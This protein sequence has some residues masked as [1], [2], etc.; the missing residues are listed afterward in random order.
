M[1]N[2][3]NH[4][5]PLPFQMV[6]FWPV[7]IMFLLLRKLS[8]DL[9]LKINVRENRRVLKNQ[10]SKK[11]QETLDTRHRKQWIQDTGNSGY[12]TQETVDTRHRKQWI[13]DTGNSGYKTQETVKTRHPLFHV[14]CIH[15]FLCLVSTVSCVLYPLFPVS[16][17]HCFLC[18]VVFFFFAFLRQHW[19]HILNSFT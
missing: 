12:K 16:C 10:H 2:N 19:V 5:H 11:T 18:F 14:S 17:F 3:W 13:Q 15:C 8:S 1:K 7:L 9:I 4:V 6:H